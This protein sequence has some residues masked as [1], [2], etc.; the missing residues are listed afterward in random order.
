M[1][2][3]TNLSHVREE[4]TSN[5]NSLVDAQQPALRD[6]IRETLAFENIQDT[7]FYD[8]VLRRPRS[9][10]NFFNAALQRQR[11]AVG[12]VEPSGNVLQTFLR[13]FMS[14]IQ[15]QGLTHLGVE[16]SNDIDELTTSFRVY[17]GQLQRRNVAVPA[18]LQGLVALERIDQSVADITEELEFMSFF[19]DAVAG[20]HDV[21]RDV[22]FERPSAWGLFIRDAL[23]G[24]ET[25]MTLI[26]D[27]DRQAVIQIRAEAVRLV[28]AGLLPDLNQLVANFQQ[29]RTISRHPAE[30][31]ESIDVLIADNLQDPPEQAH[32]PGFKPKGPSHSENHSSSDRDVVDTIFWPDVEKFL[33]TRTGSR[34]RCLCFCSAQLFIPKLSSGEASQHPDKEPVQILKCLH[35]VG[36][37]CMRAW[38]TQSSR[39]PYCNEPLG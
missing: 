7:V 21:F 31:E 25:P 29:Q 34:P 20:S 15:R 5:L 19:N 10:L 37:I 22:S 16:G 2:N 32:F 1:E 36:M 24:R 9:A 11:R 23:A 17:L 28:T 14:T 35:M 3:M 4:L 27:R 26:V 13:N 6:L 8:L 18:S 33:S 39:C 12:I 38:L 30:A